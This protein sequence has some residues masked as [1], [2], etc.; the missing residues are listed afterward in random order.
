MGRGWFVLFCALSTSAFAVIYDKDDRSEVYTHATSSVVRK[1]SQSVALVT[2]RD[3]LQPLSSGNYFLKTKTFAEYE[4]SIE[5]PLCKTE[6]F[7]NQPVPDGSAGTGFLVRPYSHVGSGF[8]AGTDLFVTAGHVIEDNADCAKAAFVFGYAMQSENQVPLS[9]PTKDV[10]FCKEVIA[11]INTEDIDYALVRLD[12][13][14]TDRTALKMTE[15]ISATSL[16]MIGHGL[17]LPQKVSE[18][19]VIKSTASPDYILA[20]LDTYS[21]NSGG[22]VFDPKTGEVIGILVASEP[23]DITIL[24][25][26][27]AGCWYSKVYCDNVATS[28]VPC[29]DDQY[30]GAKIVRS[31]FILDLLKGLPA[32]L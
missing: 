22:P 16:S 12:R 15:S 24:G 25:D 29:D 31:R 11:T 32:G 26:W 7:Q 14:V 8:L 10:Y 30:R 27:P 9:F 3:V 5:E 18:N 21:G 28:T 6:R 17:G 13:P 1:L 4:L 23:T 20:T 2:K 19:G